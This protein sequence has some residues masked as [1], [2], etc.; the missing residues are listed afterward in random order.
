M[1][2]DTLTEKILLV[3]HFVASCNTLDEFQKVIYDN[4]IKDPKDLKRKAG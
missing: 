1:K 2:L 4:N 3:E